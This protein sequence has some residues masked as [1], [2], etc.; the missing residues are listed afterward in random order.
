MIADAA[1]DARERVVFLDDAKRFVVIPGADMGDVAL[2]ALTGGTG[3]AAR[4]DTLFLDGVGG[5]DRLRIEPKGGAARTQT[6]V[7]LVR[8]LDWTDLRAVAAAYTFRRID[9]TRHAANPCR[10]VSRGTIEP[11]DFGLGQDIDVGMPPGLHQFGR[12]GAHGAVV[13]GKSLVELRHMT[14]DRGLGLHQINLEALLGEIE[15]RLHPGDPAAHHHDRTHRRTSGIGGIP[16][17][18][19]CWL[20]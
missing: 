6:F 9:E 13:G 12:N 4:G 8:Q 20:T 15:T 11:E 17:R 19:G 14:A 2:G 3:V 18:I 1:A 5:G 16:S 10:E 7:E